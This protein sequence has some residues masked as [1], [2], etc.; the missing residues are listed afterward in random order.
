MRKFSYF[1]LTALTSLI[2]L[3][4]LNAFTTKSFFLPSAEQVAIP[5]DQGSKADILAASSF[6]SYDIVELQETAANSKEFI[7]NNLTVLYSL[8]ITLVLFNFVIQ[9]KIIVQMVNLFF[10][11]RQKD[12]FANFNFR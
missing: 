10:Q 3:S 2:T 11:F 8:C 1:L 6:A 4:S 5:F 7:S 12:E 9:I